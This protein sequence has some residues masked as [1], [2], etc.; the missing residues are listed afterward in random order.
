MTGLSKYEWGRACRFF[1]GFKESPGVIRTAWEICEL[2]RDDTATPKGGNTLTS[3]GGSTATLI[4]YPNTLE[5]TLIEK[6]GS[7]GSKP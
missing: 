4:P 6:G 3:E 2:Y 1:P 7:R 5:D